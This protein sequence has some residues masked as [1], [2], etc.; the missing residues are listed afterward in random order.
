MLKAE[1]SGRVRDH[2]IY[3]TRSRE[4]M[5]SQPPPRKPPFEAVPFFSRCSN[6]TPSKS[7]SI[8]WSLDLL[9]N[10]S[11][12]ILLENCTGP[13]TEFLDVS[14]ETVLYVPGFEE[15]PLSLSELGVGADG[16]TTYEILPGA[17][18]GTFT[19]AAFSGSGMCLG[20]FLNP[21][22]N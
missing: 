18:T 22:I 3:K 15:Q 5:E 6:S 19:A 7:C 8:S 1:R 2:G 13:T 12:A 14:A 10:V 11:F 17:P 4:T 9:C 21:D 20:N 16:R